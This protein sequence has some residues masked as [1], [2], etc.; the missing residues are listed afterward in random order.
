MGLAASQARF[1]AITSRKMNCEFQ[2]MQIAQ[3][4]LS[5]TRDLQAA[6]QKYQNSLNATK[7]VWDTDADEVYDLSYDIMMN[8]SAL[9]DYNP[10][11]I[12]DTQG[13]LV[14]SEKMFQAAVTAGII[15]KNGDPIQGASLFTEGAAD[16]K[17]DGSRNAFLNALGERGQVSQSTIDSITK[18]ENSYTKSGVGGDILDKTIAN[19]LT[20]T[21]FISELKSKY[22]KTEEGHEAG[23]LKYQ[24]DLIS[25]LGDK[26][27]NGEVTDDEISSTFCFTTSPDPEKDKG[28]FIITNNGQALTKDQ[29][30][31]L[32][33]GDILS[34]K[35]AMTVVGTQDLAP[36]SEKA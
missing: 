29:L 11:L 10:Y 1:L 32:S 2:S 3:E 19:A 28:K 17:G 18:L 27:G 36:T 6:S 26:D 13:K 23:D 35:Y 25:L 4:K 8:P 22:D 7:L 30:Q 16:A 15:D 24:L 12:T 9:N 20:S 34:G 14:L 31:N 33:L 5:V 21:A